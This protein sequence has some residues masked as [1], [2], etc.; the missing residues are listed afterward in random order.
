M[1]RGTQGMVACDS[2]YASNAGLEMLQSGGNAVDAAVAASFALAVTR[3][4]S[5]GLGGGCFTILRLSSGEVIVQDARETAPSSATADMFLRRSKHAD[6]SGPPP[7][8]YGF[9]AVGVPGVVAG[10]CQLLEQHGS[11]SLSEVI[12]PAL[13]LAR[14]GFPIDHHYVETAESALKK[15]QRWPELKQIGKYVYQTHL[16][17]GNL[18][19][20]GDTLRQPNLAKLLEAIAEHGPEFFYLGPVADAIEEQMNKH[21][22][23][24]RQSDLAKY[25]VRLR[26]PIRGNYRGY[27]IISMPPSSSGGVALVE[28]L[29]LLEPFN[30][31]RTIKQDPDL[32]MHYQIEAMKHAFADRSRFLGDTDFV[33]VP[34]ERLTA[35]SYAYLLAQT[36]DREKSKTLD[37]YGLAAIPDDAGTSHLC[38]VDATG[39]VV[40][41][42][43][44]INTGFGSLVAIDEWGLI[45]NNQMDDFVSEPGKPNAY[46]LIQ[47]KSNAIAPGKRP[48]SSMT[49]TIVLKNGEPF[50]MLGASGGPRIITSVLRVLLGVIDYEESLE[51]AMTALRPHHQWQPDKVY[52]N[53]DPPAG[54]KKT[55]QRRGHEI[56]SKSKTG[57]VQAILRTPNG[58]LGACDPSKGGKP[59]GY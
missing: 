7:S 53:F 25:R 34:V 55:L 56:A 59:A 54:L 58:W 41:S 38:V 12:A 11:K 15:Y 8:R 29:N 42:T 46:G 37:A 14:D 10:R 49:P 52:F 39:N 36:M 51:E 57:I 22:G 2:V 6:Q 30:L 27:E 26:K 16:N 19:S 13:R 28:M 20:V 18:R 23:I 48:L 4:Y 5:T 45:L 40:V 33:K 35:K 50:L 31:T 44:T 9:A 43:E 24:M 17:N 1:A 3:P 47:S 21:G 32:A